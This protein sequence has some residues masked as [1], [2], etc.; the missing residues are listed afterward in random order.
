MPKQAPRVLKIALMLSPESEY[1]RGVMRGIADFAADHPQWRCRVFKP[2][3]AGLLELGRWAPDGAVAMLNARRLVPK[4]VG[5][6]RPIAFV[7][8]PHGV[9]RPMLVQS[10]DVAVGRLGA[11]HLLERPAAAFGFVGL[12]EGDFVSTRAEAF[13]RTIVDA[14]HA[15]SLFQPFGRT[16]G[17]RE[18]AA[19]AA[20]LRR[21]PKPFAVMAC[22]DASGRLVLEVGRDAG[23]RVPDELSVVGV[24]NEDP[25][26]RLVWPG[27]SSVNLATDEI[28]CRAAGLLHRALMGAMPT[29]TVTFVPPLG[30]VARGSTRQLALEDPLLTKVISAIH[31][32]VSMPKS[33]GELLKLVPISRISL[34]RK[35][36]RYL[37]RTPLQEMRRVRIDR[38]RQLLRATDLPLKNIAAHCGYAGASRLIE[39]FEKEV[40][41]T[42]TTYRQ[43]GH[44]RRRNPAAA[45]KA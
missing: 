8:K 35:F 31:E 44:R 18:T 11:E 13:R 4:L 2:D 22:N 15:C 33:V 37:D 12:A 3:A 40:G 21:A 7:C 16:P 38:A 45:E 41:V 34:E 20:W 14:G 29:R 25:L 10:D 6:G 1:G 36:R 19:L 27:L 9:D 28:G 5:L 23:L 26:S 43:Q 17:P 32:S 39:A 42:P 30:V 24:D